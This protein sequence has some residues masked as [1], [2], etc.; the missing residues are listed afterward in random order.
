M[1]YGQCQHPVLVDSNFNREKTNFH[2]LPLTCSGIGCTYGGIGAVVLTNSIDLTSSLKTLVSIF[3]S[4][5]NKDEFSCH[6]EPYCDYNHLASKNIWFLNLLN[7]A[8]FYSVLLFFNFCVHMSILSMY[9]YVMYMHMCES[10]WVCEYGYMEARRQPRVCV[11]S[12]LPSC[13]RHGLFVVYLCCWPV[14]PSYNTLQKV[15]SA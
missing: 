6:N 2:H 15:L 5:H 14:H 7:P 12:V 4:V 10:S 1:T 3:S 13:V 11:Y 9:V 8:L